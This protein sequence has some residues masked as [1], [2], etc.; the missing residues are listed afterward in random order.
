MLPSNR[1]LRALIPALLIVPPA[2]QH[3]DAQPSLFGSMDDPSEGHRLARWDRTREARLLGGFSLIGAQWRMALGGRFHVEGSAGSLLWDGT[4]RAGFYGPYDPDTDELYDVART[5]RYVRLDPAG[6][7]FTYV[8]LGPVRRGRL[9]MGH[10][11]SFFDGAASWDERRLGLEARL[12]ND[13]LSI[14]VVAE[15]VRLGNVVGVRST[16]RPMGGSP[17]DATRSL[18]FGGS[19]ITD[20]ATRDLVGLRPATAWEADVRLEAVR[21]GSFALYPFVS[22]ARLVGYGEGLMF[23]GDVEADNFIEFAR[24]YARLAVHYGSDRFVPGY[25]GAFYPVANL[26]SRIVEGDDVTVTGTTIS[27]VVATTSVLAEGRI[28]V[29]ERFEFW[30]AFRRHYGKQALSTLHIRL[31]LRARRFRLGI[32]QDRGGLTTFWSAF[33]A[34]GSEATLTFST[35][36]R[37][38]GSIWVHALARYTYER[39]PDDADGAR[40]LAQRRFEPRVGFRIPF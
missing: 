19:W 14:F 23:G 3:A 18:E 40:Y 24:L 33:G 38:L 32:A 28:H 7:R 10:L 31:Y 15:D 12:G 4:L 25:F 39:L 5:L 35:E 6:R 26:R 22:Y 20:R 9:G 16:F 2:I 30:F 21:R 37:V 36:Y 34:L 13:A 11:M 29:F 8:R 1:L 17:S 27:D